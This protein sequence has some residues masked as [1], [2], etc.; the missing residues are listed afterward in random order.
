VRKRQ[1]GITPLAQSSEV[2]QVAT[3]FET[4]L[5]SVSSPGFYHDVFVRKQP[6]AMMDARLRKR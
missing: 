2:W 6:S 5:L 1:A 3:L 4:V